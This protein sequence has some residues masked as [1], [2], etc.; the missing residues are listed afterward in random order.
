MTMYKNNYRELSFHESVKEINNLVEL[1]PYQ[2]E[3]LNCRDHLPFAVLKYERPVKV[4]PLWRLTAPLYFVYIL[5]SVLII[6]PIRWIAIGTTS[7][8]GNEWHYRL[9]VWWSRKLNA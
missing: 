8:N 7:V 3:K 2:K 4:R 9:Y 6:H 5:L 1:S